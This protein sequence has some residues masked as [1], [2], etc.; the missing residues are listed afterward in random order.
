MRRKDAFVKG[1]RVLPVVLGDKG[2]RTRCAGWEVA[3]LAEDFVLARAAVAQEVLVLL[4][5]KVHGNTSLGKVPR[6]TQDLVLARV[7]VAHRAS[8]ARRDEA[9]ER[10]WC[11]P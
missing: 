9:H 11:G 4:R 10:Q 7:A 8:M 5:D 2:N 3:R 1:V 6:F